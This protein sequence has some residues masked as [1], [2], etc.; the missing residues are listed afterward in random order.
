MEHSIKMTS[1][2]QAAAD[3][4]G[5][6]HLLQ[7]RHGFT[8]IEKKEQ[9]ERESMELIMKIL[10]EEGGI[11]DWPGTESQEQYSRERG[12]RGRGR[13]RGRGGRGNSR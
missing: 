13:A 5:I 9:E 4:W 8:E 7:P 3:V 6:T 2:M 1:S 10:E 11:V 12:E